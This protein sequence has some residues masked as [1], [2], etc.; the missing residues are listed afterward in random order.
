MKEELIAP[1]G[2]T[3]ALC[4]A[5]LARKYDLRKQGILRIYCAGCLPRGKECAYLKK[6]CGRMLT[7]YRF[8]YECPDYPCDRLKHLDKRYR[9]RYHMSMIENLNFIKDHGMAEFIAEQQ[10]KWQCPDCGDTI[11][12]HNGIC[13]NCGLEILKTKKLRYSWEDK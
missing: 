11:C 7:Q 3:C 10:E 13:F 5:Y 9:T 12:C 1:C 6:R 8:C 4:S 2:M